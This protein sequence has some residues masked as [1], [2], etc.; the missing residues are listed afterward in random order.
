[1]FNKKKSRLNWENKKKVERKLQHYYIREV[2]RV[3]NITGYKKDSQTTEGNLDR[4]NE[5]NLFYS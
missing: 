2:W 1:M 4:A 3:M 5:F